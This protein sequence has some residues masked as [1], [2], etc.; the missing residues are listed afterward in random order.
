[1][2]YPKALK[3]LR[4]V[5]APNVK[6]ANVIGKLRRIRTEVGLLMQQLDDTLANVEDDQPE[7]HA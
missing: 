1:M 4:R 7:Q 2:S 6:P 3:D 5:S